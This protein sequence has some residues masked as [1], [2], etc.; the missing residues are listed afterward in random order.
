MRFRIRARN[1][2]D[3]K[4]IEAPPLGKRDRWLPSAIT[5]RDGA[6]QLCSDEASGVHSGMEKPSCAD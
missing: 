6:R 2:C 5:I 3:P 1:C 4:A